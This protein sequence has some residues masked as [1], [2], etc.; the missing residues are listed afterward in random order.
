MSAPTSPREPT[1]RRWAVVS[2]R[3]GRWMLYL[4]IHGAG[5]VG[6]TLLITWGLFVLFFLA[7]G[8]LSFDGLM[9]HLANLSNRYL[10][11]GPD[12]VGAFKHLILVAHLLVSA[13]VIFLR[14][15]R[16]YPARALQGTPRHG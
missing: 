9:H 3:D 15:H 16:I 11:A 13:A 10:T 4:L 8:G 2:A 6:T 7:I 12:R 5:F 14:R 1:G